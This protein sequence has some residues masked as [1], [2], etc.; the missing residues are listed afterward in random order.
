MIISIDIETIPNADAIPLL[1]EPDVALGNLKDPDKIAA[2]VEAAKAAQ[3]DKL[4]LD[5]LYARICCVCMVAGQHDQTHLLAE[6]TDA[7]EA[8]L[9]AAV[10]EVL[11]RPTVRLLS[12]NGIGF[13]LPFVYKRALLLRVPPPAGLPALS[14]WT[15]RYNRENHIDLMQEWGG[16]RDYAKLD[17]VARMVLGKQK[18]EI[19]FRQ[20][21]AMIAQGEGAK[22]GKYCLEDTRLVYELY[23]AM[24]GFLI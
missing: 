5:P 16:W 23:T 21:A 19:D 18:I 12:W 20:F 14:H 15:R 17:D 22:I 2:K 6:A 10:L 8:K 11:A 24:L 9:I 1:P 13:D 7:A 3:I 4:A